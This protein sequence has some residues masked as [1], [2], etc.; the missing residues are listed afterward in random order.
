MLDRSLAR[1]YDLKLTKD[2]AVLI[3]DEDASLCFTEAKQMVGRASRTQG[4]QH[5][6]AVIFDHEFPMTG[7]LREYLVAK[8]QIAQDDEGPE[9]MRCLLGVLDKHPGRSKE[10][11]IF[12]EGKWRIKK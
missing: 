7:D 8:E 12:N 5:G 2:A 1:G 11:A 10:F 4:I 9:V 6:Y 3:F